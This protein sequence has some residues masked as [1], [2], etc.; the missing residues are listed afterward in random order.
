MRWLP[1]GDR[2]LSVPAE[3]PGWPQPH[4]PLGPALDQTQPEPEPEPGQ[5]QN[6]TKPILPLIPHKSP[7]MRLH[8]L[9]RIRIS[10]LA[11]AIL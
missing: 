4:P 2:L 7:R 6:T 11:I 1:G 3:E 5:N 9:Q 10:D 8:H